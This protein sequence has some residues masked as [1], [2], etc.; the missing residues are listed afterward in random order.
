MQLSPTQRD[1]VLALA[2]GAELHWRGG[3]QRKPVAYLVLER[4]TRVVR[5]DTLATL[6]RLGLVEAVDRDDEAFKRYRVTEQGRR[7]TLGG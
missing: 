7:A 6:V 3:H 5:A 1:V 4:G 2:Q